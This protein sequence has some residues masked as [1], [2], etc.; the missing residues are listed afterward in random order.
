MSDSA[1]LTM[2]DAAKRFDVSTRTI[3]RL[4]AEGEL[5]C[6][7]IG[8]SVRFSEDQLDAYT[9]RRTAAAVVTGGFNAQFVDEKQRQAVRNFLKPFLDEYFQAHRG[10][11]EARGKAA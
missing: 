2:E 10:D 6:T 3:K 8:R 1:T 5:Q 7:R 11:A 9:A 4:L